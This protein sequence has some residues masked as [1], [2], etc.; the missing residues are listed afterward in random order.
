MGGKY[1]L[2]A[3]DG[4]ELVTTIIVL[5][6]VAIAAVALRVVSRRIR[7][8]SLGLDDYLML[9]AICF[10]IAST[11]L[12]ITTVTH[13]GVGLHVE[14]VD[15]EDL[16]YTMKMI[17]PMQLLYSQSIRIAIYITGAVVWA[18]GFNIVLESFLLWQPIEFNYNPFLP[19]G[20]CGDRNAAFVVAGVLNMFT[21]YMV[22]PL[23]VPYIWKLQL[24][25]GRKIGLVVTFCLGLF[26]TA[27]SMA[28]VFSLI[29]IDFA[30]ATYTLPM[31]LMW[32]I[33][34]E[35]LAIVAANLPV[36]RHVF[37]TNLPRN[38]MG[39]S[40]RKPTESDAR[41]QSSADPPAGTLPRMQWPPAI[42]PVQTSG[43]HPTIA[44]AS[45]VCPDL[46]PCFRG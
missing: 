44:A 23:P 38:W 14:E 45:Y 16:I 42:S 11:I 43:M 1:G 35:Q 4:R 40:R 30:D 7:N 29:S 19:G 37:A 13:G 10:I 41:Y 26:V 27:I 20:S 28:R 36:L 21:D 18:W 17:I 39:S 24:S 9:I 31:P 12:V 5:G 8:V 22:M 2:K 25:I 32:S 6:I 15:P 34:K 33:V 46:I 3:K